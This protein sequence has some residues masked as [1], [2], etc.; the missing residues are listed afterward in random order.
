MVGEDETHI[1]PA[2]TRFVAHVRVQT[3]LPPDGFSRG[4]RFLMPSPNTGSACKRWCMFA[5]WMVRPADGIDLGLW[6]HVDPSALVMPVDTHVFRIATALDLTRRRQADWKA[7]LE[8]TARMRTL[9]PNDPVRYDF[10][11]AHVGISGDG[12][13]ALQHP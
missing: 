12:L 4:L 6:G 11:L 7:A 5:R 9:F 1:G 8:I 10:A 3:A 13:Q 2:L